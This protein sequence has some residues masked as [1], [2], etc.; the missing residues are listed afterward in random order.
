MLLGHINKTYKCQ[1]VLNS[2]QLKGHLFMT[3]SLNIHQWWKK[4]FYFRT[5]TAC[6]F[7]LGF[8]AFETLWVKMSLKINLKVGTYYII[9][10]Y[11]FPAT[12]KCLSSINFVV[13]SSF[14]VSQYS[15]FVLFRISVKHR[16]SPFTFRVTNYWFT[17]QTQKDFF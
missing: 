1:S 17:Y 6:I 13:V 16:S 9:I 2:F 5:G 10:Y 12:E 14:S 15:S 7:S 11:P 4:V 3:P 8:P